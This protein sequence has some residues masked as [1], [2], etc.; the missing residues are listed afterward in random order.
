MLKL[1]DIMSRDVLTVAPDMTMR[2]AMELF[3][4]RHVSGAPVVVGATVVGVVSS[5]DLLSLTQ[6][7]PVAPVVESEPGS[8]SEIEVD[9]ELDDV[10][11][12]G[13]T[14]EDLLGSIGGVPAPYHTEAWTEPPTDASEFPP[15]PTGPEWS[16][17]DERTVD[18]AMSRNIVALPPD[19]DVT[20]AAEVMQRLGIHRVLVMEGERLVGIVS[21]RDV[22]NAVAQH[23]LTARRYVFRRGGPRE[24]REDTEGEVT[25]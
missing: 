18:E 5:S 11:V 21:A 7:S 2:D 14:W 10:A 8:A 4:T 9:V 16:A 12:N 25:P 19:V 23:R 1:R 6:M 13:S 3:A 22:A 17:L 24:E 15:A 20:Q